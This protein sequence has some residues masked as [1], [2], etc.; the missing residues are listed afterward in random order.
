TWADFELAL[1]QYTNYINNLPEE[2]RKKESIDFH[3][4]LTELM[5]DLANYLS[6][7][8]KSAED[9]LN[10]PS[11]TATSYFEELPVGQVSMISALVSRK[12]LTIQ[13]VTLNYTEILKETLL[14]FRRN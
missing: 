13:F 6:K 8:E 7:Q 12:P 14:G 11:F 2:K 3:E 1:G 5:E 10:E 9:M 4:E